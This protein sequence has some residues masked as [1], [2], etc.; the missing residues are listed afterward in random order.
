[1]GLEDPA[2]YCRDCHRWLPIESFAYKHIALGT[3]QSRCRACQS[4]RSR[5]HYQRHSAS[6]LRRAK[7]NN[8][9]VRIENRHRLH[10]FLAAQRCLDC[11]TADFA[12]LEFDHRDP[13]VKVADVSTLV[14]KVC[15]WSRVQ[16]EIDRCDVVCANCHRRRTARQFGWYKLGHPKPL[17][18][19][20]LP[21][22]GTPEYER[23]K[24]VRSGQARR[25]RNRLFI[26]NYL[27]ANP[28]A[29]CGETDPVV[30][31]FDHLSEKDR[32]IGWL[33]PTSCVTSIRRELQKCRVLCANCHRRHTAT[34]AG[35]RR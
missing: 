11:G 4:V 24:S 23:T 7:T 2:R 20:A 1:M 15:A 13:S 14:R 29:L 26:W 27:Q 10:E 5:E 22:R 19:P 3:R 8:K 25:R 6:Y 18:L 21:K 31:E 33:M 17:E 12:V 30:L 16:A 32:D 34:Q 35:R 9:R 28:C